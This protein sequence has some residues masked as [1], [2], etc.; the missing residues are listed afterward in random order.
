LKKFCDGHEK[1]MDKKWAGLDKEIAGRKKKVVG[2]EA[3]R[4]LAKQMEA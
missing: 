2:R 1:M 4:G 3:T